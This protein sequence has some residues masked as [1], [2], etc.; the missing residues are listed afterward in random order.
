MR[1]AIMSRV[2]KPEYD[3]FGIQTFL[4]G[5]LHGLH[6]LQSEH[7]IIALVDPEQTALNHISHLGSRVI[8]VLPSTSSPTGKLWW[9]HIAVGQVCNQYRVD[10]LYTP[11]HVRPL[12]A[13][14]P[15]VVSVLD[16]MYHRFPHYWEMSDQLY[17]RLAVSLLT[18]RSAAIAALSQSTRSDI[19]AF[20]PVPAEK[21]EVI[22]PGVPDGF[23]PLPP[24]EHGNLRERYRLERP[25]ILYVGSFHPRKNITAMLN[26][27]AALAP[28]IPHD[29]VIIGPNARS[30]GA[31]VQRVQHHP[32]RDRMRF[33]GFVPRSDLPLFYNQADLF[34][35]PSSYE[36]FGFPVLEALACGCP[37]I[38]TRVS[39]LP[40]VAGDAALLVEPGDTQALINAIARVLSDS[41]LRARLREQG[42]HQA[43]RF[44]WHTTATKTLALLEQVAQRGR[45]VS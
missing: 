34:V 42:L 10:A 18:S 32:C 25:F 23:A 20:L 3:G 5:L 15:V 22:Y 6:D 45:Q 17:F 38:T 43:Q 2:L 39:S 11:G 1:F 30:S 13:P 41:G 29:L 44:S 26:A 4:A 37:T 8:P 7:E 19:F 14:C 28:Q 33:V 27:F 21:V 9:D 31:V 12:Y 40:E 35:F 36:G 16:M 24:D